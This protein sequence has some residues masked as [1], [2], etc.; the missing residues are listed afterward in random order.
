VGDASPSAGPDLVAGGD[1]LQRRPI[2]RHDQDLQPLARPAQIACVPT[3]CPIVA[4]HKRCIAYARAA[5]AVC[6]AGA[7]TSTNTERVAAPSDEERD[8]VG[9]KEVLADW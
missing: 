6:A 5:R 2:C 4:V 8:I 3:D 1:V 7:T 9:L